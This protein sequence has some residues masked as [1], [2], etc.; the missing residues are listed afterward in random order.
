MIGAHR[1]WSNETSY[2]G[3]TIC[4]LWVFHHC[5]SHIPV[6]HRRKAQATE[7]HTQLRGCEGCSL[8]KTPV[9]MSYMFLHTRVNST[10]SEVKAS[11]LYSDIKCE[12]RENCTKRFKDKRHKVGKTVK[13][14]SC[15]YIYNKQLCTL[16]E[17]KVQG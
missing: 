7:K 9:P 1:H 8:Q 2:M 3:K 5:V 14:L 12:K 16:L 15:G 10:I 17:H 4:W 6:A 13:V 11:N